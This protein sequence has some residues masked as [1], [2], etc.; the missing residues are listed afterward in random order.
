MDSD[1]LFFEYGFSLILFDVK[2]IRK[3]K[4]EGKD[5]VRKI[6]KK[7]YK[8]DLDEKRKKV[9]D[10]LVKLDFEEVKDIELNLEIDNEEVMDEFVSVIFRFSIIC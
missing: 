5:N 2:C 4:V 8:I 1:S 6:W 9:G 10:D 7:K 3:R